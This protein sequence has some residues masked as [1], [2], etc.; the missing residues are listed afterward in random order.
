MGSKTLRVVAVSFLVGLIVGVGVLLLVIPGIY[1]ADLYALAIPA[2][3]LEDIGAGQA[4]SRSSELTKGAVWRMVVIYFLTATF[5][6]V[7]LVALTAGVEALG[8]GLFRHTGIISKEVVEEILTSLC[9]TLFGPISAIGLT[10]AYYDRR[11]R[12]EAF[13]IE[14]MMDLMSAGE[15]HAVGTSA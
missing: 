13:D 6:I 9:E 15:E 2:V 8:P 3:I 7:I 4:L 12:K 10:L 1:W 11:V 5:A 14:H